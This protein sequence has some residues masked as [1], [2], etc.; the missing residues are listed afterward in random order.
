[1]NSD[2]RIAPRQRVIKS[3]KIISLDRTTV[4]D[5]T[6]RNISNTGAQLV[7]ENQAVVPKDFFF[8]QPK[9]NTMCQAKVMW[10]REKLVGVHFTSDMGPPPAT[11]RNL[12]T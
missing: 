12:R 3:A 8:L 4:A 2:K 9:E 6:I 5:C 7:V 11:M 1:M 10:R